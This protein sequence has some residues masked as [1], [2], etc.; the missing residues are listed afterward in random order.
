MCMCWRVHTCAPTSPYLCVYLRFRPLWWTTA[1]SCLI[2]WFDFDCPI[3]IQWFA[4]EYWFESLWYHSK[5]MNE[6]L[7]SIQ[8]T[9]NVSTRVEKISWTNL[10]TWKMRHTKS[11]L[12]SSNFIKRSV[13]IANWSITQNRHYVFVVIEY[14]F[15]AKTNVKQLLQILIR[16][17]NEI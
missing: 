8:T 7:Y 1:S 17:S 9:N 16:N 10:C 11:I 13:E 3:K 4:F 15:K 6:I 2:H 12:F 14:E 5:E